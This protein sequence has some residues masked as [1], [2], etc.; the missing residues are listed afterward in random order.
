MLKI[1]VGVDKSEESPV[2]TMLFAQVF[3]NQIKVHI[4][5][6]QVF[7]QENNQEA[8]IL[9]LLIELKPAAQQI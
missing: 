5:F 2:Y 4:Q 1:L 9:D 8:C 6:P 7:F 3:H